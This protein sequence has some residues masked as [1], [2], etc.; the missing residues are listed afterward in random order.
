MG[1]EWC[2]DKIKKKQEFFLESGLLSMAK[3]LCNPN[4]KSL[5]E[6]LNVSIWYN[7]QSSNELLFLAEWH[8]N[9]R[10]AD[11]DVLKENGSV[12]TFEELQKLYNIDTNMFVN[13]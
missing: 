3:I 6:L 7:K 12:M 1:P 4:T 10:Y 8:R 11:G 13:L 2:N 5:S 9:G